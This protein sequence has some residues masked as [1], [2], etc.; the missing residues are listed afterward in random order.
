M[1][2]TTLYLSLSLS[3]SLL[4]SLLTTLRNEVSDDTNDDLKVSEQ[5]THDIMSTK[6]ENP[7]DQLATE[8][9]NSED[10]PNADPS[11][12]KLS[13]PATVTDEIEKVED[14]TGDVSQSGAT[15]SPSKSC[16]LKIKSPVVSKVAE[17]HHFQ[18]TRSFSTVEETPA[19]K[20]T[21]TQ[22]NA[23]K[24]LPRKDIAHSRSDQL[25]TYLAQQE[26][27]D[28]DDESKMMA[29]S[30]TV[31]D[32]SE[33]VKCSSP[34]SICEE[35]EPMIS[36]DTLIMQFDY[37]SNDQPMSLQHES[38]SI[39]SQNHN[40]SHLRK[41]GR[42]LTGLEADVAKSNYERTKSR[43]MN[44]RPRLGFTLKLFFP[45]LFC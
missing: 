21:P 43:V 40:S 4:Y 34:R 24:D 3:L 38:K 28:D 13:H 17:T 18:K 14:K 15:T 20:T 44:S 2:Y 16:T 36:G 10:Q 8:S 35:V 27:L 19:K 29:S 11:D 5:L 23:I 32:H 31:V 1:N 26:E 30:S 37:F 41:S 45:F 12:L 25:E 9:T 42:D 7:V 33:M 6:A 39:C 22:L